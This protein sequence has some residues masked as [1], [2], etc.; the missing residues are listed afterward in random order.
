MPEG[1]GYSPIPRGFSSPKSLTDAAA[2]GWVQRAVDGV[3]DIQR[4][5]LNAIADVTLN[6]AATTTVVIDARISYN[7]ALLFMPTT[8]DAAAMLVALYVPPSEMMSGQATI[9]HA[10]TINADCTYRVAILG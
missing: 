4:G 2:R 3:N 7:S 8:A 1:P 5:K 6:V 10:N 9:H